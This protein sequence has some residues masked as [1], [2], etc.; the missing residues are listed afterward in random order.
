LFGQPEL[1]EKLS[2]P[3]M[4]QLKERITHSFN[5]SPFP[6][7]DT[8]QYLNFRLRAVG[9]KG[10]DVFNKKTAGVVK[11]YSDGLTRRINIIADKS[12]LAAFSESSH[13]VTPSHIKLA[14]QDSEFKKAD[15]NKNSIYLAGGIILSVAALIFGYYMGSHNPEN[16]MLP[17]T[18]DSRAMPEQRSGVPNRVEQER[19]K[20]MLP[21]S[22]QQAAA[23]PAVSTQKPLSKNNKRQN[24]A[25]PSGIVE[26]LAKTKQWLAEAVDN[27]YSIQLFL[28]RTSNADKVEAFLQD[29]LETLDIARVY[30]YET[31]INGHAWYS[32]VYSDYATQSKAI[33]SLDS[34][35]LS[36]KAN[37]AYLRRISALKKDNR[38]HD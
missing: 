14:A 31:V 38:R 37:G 20:Q 5:L 21:A 25:V 18:A 24:K 35:S 12:L 15:I 34:L 28:A 10:P 36:L 32:V 17:G 30:I 23:A 26:R 6:P 3:H 29:A 4:R 19:L 9:Y 11:K 2:A 16:Q 27:H 33:E 1:D 22:V 7:D 13:T 8:L